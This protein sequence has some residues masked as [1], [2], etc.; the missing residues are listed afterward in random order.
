MRRYSDTLQKARE[1]EAASGQWRRIAR[2]NNLRHP[3][4]RILQGILNFQSGGFEA[5]TLL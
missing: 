2:I 3:I 5:L 1:L 4:A